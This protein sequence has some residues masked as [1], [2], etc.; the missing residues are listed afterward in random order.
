MKLPCEIIVREILP[1]IKAIVAKELI[2]HYGLSQLEVASRLGITQASVS[3]YLT[4]KRGQTR[5]REVTKLKETG[6]KIAEA[7]TKKSASV[8]DIMRI[9]CDACRTLRSG[10]LICR[11]HEDLIPSLRQETC[12]LCIRR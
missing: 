10:D 1:A 2:E 9:V 8:L 11:L 7:I 3:H 4:G 5:L 6:K 12:E